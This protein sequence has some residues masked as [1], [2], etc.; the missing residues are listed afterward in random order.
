MAWFTF[1]RD[2]V[3]FAQL[4]IDQ[5]TKPMIVRILRGKTIQLSEDPAERDLEFYQLIHE[6]FGTDNYSSIYIVGGRL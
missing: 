6:S 5:K 4:V 2:Q 3:S 1:D